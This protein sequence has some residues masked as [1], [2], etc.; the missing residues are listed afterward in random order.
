MS[1]QSKQSSQPVRTVRTSFFEA[2]LFTEFPELSLDDEGDGDNDDVHR[3][4]RESTSSGP[5]TRSMAKRLQNDSEAK[6]DCKTCR[7]TDKLSYTFAIERTRKRIEVII[8]FVDDD[9]DDDHRI[10]T[11]G[12]VRMVGSNGNVRLAWLS[13][14]DGRGPKNVLMAIKSVNCTDDEDQKDDLKNESTASYLIRKASS[15]PTA[16]TTAEAD[17]EQKHMKTILTSNICRTLPFTCREC[18]DSLLLMRFITGGTLHRAL[19]NNVESDSETRV[20]KW[21]MPLV[22]AI[23][24]LHTTAGISHGDLKPNNI[25]LDDDGRMKIIDFG[26]SERIPTP[27]EKTASPGTR[28][29]LQ[30]V[31]RPMSDAVLSTNLSYYCPFTGSTPDV[32]D[33][34]SLGVLIFCI[35]KGESMNTRPYF[36]YELDKWKSGFVKKT[37]FQL[38][39]LKLAV[40]C[41]SGTCDDAREAWDRIRVIC[42]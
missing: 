26:R 42:R 10:R 9:E 28:G 21:A 25:C 29:Q 37:P 6:V 7:T 40:D 23:C 19:L 35:M 39:I 20:R 38:D 22:G 13:R 8:E 2:D 36:E 16:T 11:V 12:I 30:G 33:M 1:K 15:S 27:V 5:V 41:L 34:Y 32:E 24:A 14:A 4:R 3:E 31:N 17:D 18:H